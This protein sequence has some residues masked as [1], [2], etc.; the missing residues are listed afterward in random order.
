MRRR[1]KPQIVGLNP[2]WFEI[3]IFRP[4][5][6]I[7][8]ITAV[9]TFAYCKFNAYSEKKAIELEEQRAA[10]ESIAAEERKKQESIR[11]KE[12][13][14]REEELKR[15]SIKQIELEKQ[16]TN[17]L[18]E[19]KISKRIC[20]VGTYL[21]NNQLKK[22]GRVTGYYGLE[23]VTNNDWKFD[24]D[25]NGNMPNFVDIIGY[26]EYTKSLQKQQQQEIKKNRL[27]NAQ[28]LQQLIDVEIAELTKKT[29]EKLSTNFIRLGEELYRV[30]DIKGDQLFCIK[31]GTRKKKSNYIQITYSDMIK[32]ISYIEY[33]TGII[34]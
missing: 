3:R 33:E 22:V 30:W 7:C 19:N 1:Y 18:Y 25:T 11:A 12:Q 26:S 13:E 27:E 16:R 34:K 8:L 9:I 20:P 4:L 15:E 32:C 2:K 21:R 6:K 10:E 14:E 24:I 5:F 23:V 17:T 29:K 31:K 28:K